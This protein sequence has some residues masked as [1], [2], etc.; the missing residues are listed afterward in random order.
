MSRVNKTGLEI[1]RNAKI[2]GWE[3]PKS[4]KLELVKEWLENPRSGKWL[5]LIDNADD[6]NLLF[7]SGGLAK[8]LPRSNDGAFF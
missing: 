5:L 7:G 2:P 4:K 3:D 6:F 1:A 8:S